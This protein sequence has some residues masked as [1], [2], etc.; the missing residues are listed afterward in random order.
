MQRRLD[1]GALGESNDFNLEYGERRGGARSDHCG[2]RDRR[3]DYDQLGR[4]TAHHVRRKRIR[5]RGGRDD[6]CNRAQDLLY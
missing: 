2:Q 1:D 6:Q 4:S 5:L 3:Y